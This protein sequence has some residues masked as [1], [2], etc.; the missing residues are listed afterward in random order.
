MLHETQYEC[1]NLVIK[2]SRTF[3]DIYVV[4]TSEG[5]DWGGGN[6]GG[7]AERWGFREICIKVVTFYA[8]NI[9]PSGICLFSE[10]E[11]SHLPSPP[12]RK[13]NSVQQ[14]KKKVNPTQFLRKDYEFLNTSMESQHT[15]LYAKAYFILSFI[16]SPPLLENQIIF[17]TL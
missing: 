2:R 9:L 11:R 6:W 13:E 14:K 10:T 3:S 8:Q 7:R 15:K 16:F 5:W 12:Q 4:C 17:L 1:L